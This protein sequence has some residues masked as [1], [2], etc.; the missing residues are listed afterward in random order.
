MVWSQYVYES[1]VGT[2]VDTTLRV[3][4][5]EREDEDNIHTFYE[6]Y[7]DELRQLYDMFRVLLHED[8]LLH[9][10][11]SDFS[12]FVDM[13]YYVDNDIET[14]APDHP[15][16]SRYAHILRRLRAHD[17]RRLIHHVTLS[18]F[19]DFAS[20]QRPWHEKYLNET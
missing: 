3:S 19:I 17:P 2:E 16:A 4:D 13:C 11:T 7:L 18:A 5:D 1:T 20:D 14:V 10:T 15:D 6:F 12:D 9:E 8:L